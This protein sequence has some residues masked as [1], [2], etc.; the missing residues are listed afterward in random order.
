VFLKRFKCHFELSKPCFGLF[1]SY[2]LNSLFRFKYLN[3]IPKNSPLKSSLNVYLVSYFESSSNLLWKYFNLF[4]LNSKIIE[5][6]SKR[7]LSGHPY[8][9]VDFNSLTRQP[10][11]LFLDFSSR[12][13]TNSTGPPNRS[14]S[15]SP[16]PHHLFHPNAR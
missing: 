6:N 13:P 5:S 10:I 16:A 11:F 14:A 2:D 1:S 7:E 15:S 9:F 3:P 4:D 8:S 12:W